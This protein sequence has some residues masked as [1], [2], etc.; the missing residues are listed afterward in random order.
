[1]PPE[2]PVIVAGAFVAAFAVGAVGFGD[3]LI[4]AAI[5][6]FVLE[7]AVTVP[8]MVMCG[9][10]LYAVTLVRMRRCLDFSAAVPFV[11][12]GALGVPGGAWLLTMADATLFRL[13]V[14]AFLVVYAG[15]F[16][17]V[18][19]MP[20]V[21]AGGRTADGAVGIIGGM[22]VGLAGFGAVAPAIWSGLRG[23]P[24]DRQRGAF[25]TFGLAIDVVTLVWFLINGM[26]APTVGVYFLW[27]LPATLL[28]TGLGMWFYGRLDERLF[29]RAVLGL[30]LVS[31]VLMLISTGSGLR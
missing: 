23:W 18:R 22:L 9:V 25:Q 14:G 15:V 21:T 7:P 3:A 31:G 10:L 6:L 30:L 5:W 27:C 17:L 24:M 1:M 11:V 8:L 16:L 19:A 2:V 29:R 4:V 28:G 12:G 20:R 13:G 26:I